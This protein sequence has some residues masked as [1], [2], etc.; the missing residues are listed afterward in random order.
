MKK[1]PGWFYLVAIA[2]LAHFASTLYSV[3]GK[4]PLEAT[5]LAIVLGLL[6]RQFSL[7]PK[8]CEAGIKESEKALLWGIVLLGVSLNF[9][10]I[11][12][13]GTSMLI[14]VMTTMVFGFLIISLFGRLFGL[15]SNLSLLLAVGTTICGGSA[16]AVTAPIIKA[17]EEETSYAIGTITLWG[18]LAIFI[19]PYIARLFEVSNFNFGLFAGSAIHSTPQVVGAGF[20]YS[21]LSGQ[22]ATTV[23]L[24]RNC[25]MA[26][27]ALFIAFW[28]QR[29]EKAMSGTKVNYAKAFPWFLFGFFITAALNTWGILPTNIISSITNIA[30]FLIIISMVGIGLSVNFSSFK[31]IGFR[32][33]IVGFIGALVVAGISIATISW[34]K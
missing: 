27:L 18:V 8:S 13:S 5:A 6:L 20:I 34:N 3:A 26:P 21:E 31:G 30:K 14:V 25:F 24:I 17:K 1:I 10:T 28:Y 11:I 2:T 9:N 33:L 15:S 23:K 19:Y 22:T 12:S 7:V 29:K 16:I 32:P 4:N